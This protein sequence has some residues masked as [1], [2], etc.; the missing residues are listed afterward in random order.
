MVRVRRVQVAGLVVAM[1]AMMGCGGGAGTELVVEFDELPCTTS[2]VRG[3]V[4]IGSLRVTT[5]STELD[6]DVT[7][8]P[9][10]MIRMGADGTSLSDASSTFLSPLMPF[11]YSVPFA[12]QCDGPGGELGATAVVD[13]RSTLPVSDAA[14]RVT[15]TCA[16]AE[17]DVSGP[18]GAIADGG[19]DQAGSQVP[20]VAFSRTFTVANVGTAGLSLTSLTATDQSNCT[21]VTTLA[22]QAAVPAGGATV[23]SVSVTPIAVG[24]FSCEL[25]LA[26]NDLDEAPFDLAITGTAVAAPAPEIAVENPSQVNVPDGGTDPI[27]STPAGTPVARVYTIRNI[28]SALM[29]LGTVT[30]PGSTN[31]TFGTFAQPGSPIAVSSSVAMTVTITPT[32]PGVFVCAISIPNDDPNEN[33]FDFAITGTATAALVPE[34]DVDGFADGA[35]DPVGMH[36]AGVAFTRSYGINNLGAATLTIS[37]T[38]PGTATNCMLMVTAAPGGTVAPAAATAFTVTAMA[39]AAGPFSCAIQIF[40]TDSDENPYDLTITGTGTPAPAPEIDVSVQSRAGVLTDGGAVDL[41]TKFSGVSATADFTVANVG[42][43]PLA[44]GMVTT[45][46]LVNVMVS[47]TLQPGPSVTA[48][49]TTPFVVRYTPTNPGPFSFSL[50]FTNGDSDESPFDVALSGVAIAPPDLD[51]TGPQGPI[52]DDGMDLIPG[53]PYTGVPIDRPYSLANVGLG[54]LI[55]VAV[56]I[57]GESNCTASITMA[58]TMSIAAGTSSTLVVRVTPTAPGAF[59]CDF[60]VGSNDPDEF[61]YA[62]AITGTAIGV[63]GMVVQAHPNPTIEVV[64]SSPAGVDI[65][66]T[67]LIDSTGNADL[68][69][70]AITFPTLTNCTAAVLIQPISPVAPGGGTLL[71][72]RYTPTA[73]GA[74]RC[75]VSIP[76]NT[77][78]NNPYVLGIQGSVPSV[79]NFAGMSGNYAGDGGCGINSMALAVTTTITVNNFGAN[80]TVVFTINP[81]NPNSAL[82]ALLIIFGIGGH[83][84]ELV[85]QSNFSILLQ[86]SRPGASCQES[87]SKL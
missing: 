30:F 9:S 62:V 49:G 58:P 87:M 84:C 37:S 16:E 61:P 24:P 56:I 81:T 5:T 27:G 74:F 13:R 47:V 75:E 80:G 68:T 41:G 23:F 28:G 66:R 40:N 38:V 46:N 45:A 65:Q 11:G 42:N 57:S 2:C 70:G 1:V 60:A 54:N 52:A 6:M 83:D 7:L 71:T 19:A 64:G 85:R 50:S 77:L 18:N 43:A 29:S 73:G 22:P 51:I 86:C 72:V 48:G 3:A 59:R 14:P 69:F 21:V 79:G 39:L 17:I 15:I 10:G 53:T 67:Y 26:N 55:N 33:P 63:A 36:T 35:S 76:N 34:I 82:A 8:D 20:G 78:G 32:A 25:A 44:V 4:N 31:C 12:Y